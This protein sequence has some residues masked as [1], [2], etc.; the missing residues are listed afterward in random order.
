MAS[1]TR[2]VSA[3]QLPVEIRRIRADEG[4]RL[5]ALRLRALAE[6]PLA[7]SSTLT[8]EQA[9]IESVWDERAA[10]AAA[11]SARATFVAE[12]QGQWVGIATGVARHPDDLDHSPILVG[13]FVDA[14]QRGRGVGAALVERVADWVRTLPAERLYLWATSTNRPAMALYKKCGFQRTV[15]TRPLEHTPSLVEV[16][17][18]RHLRP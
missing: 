15:E 4:L 5:R 18:V 2:R 6:A 13:M 3:D 7:F 17:M 10:G 12:E 11:G 8:R 14:T 16:L 9:F 1:G